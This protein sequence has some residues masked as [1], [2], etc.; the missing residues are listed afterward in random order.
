[1][2][3]RGGSAVCVQGRG[4]INKRTV[5][6]FIIISDIFLVQFHESLQEALLNGTINPHILNILKFRKRPWTMN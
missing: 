5:F 4:G 2:P 1:M 6:Q 3:G